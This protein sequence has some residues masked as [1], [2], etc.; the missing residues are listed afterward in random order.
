MLKYLGSVGTFIRLNDSENKTYKLLEIFSSS[1][2]SELLFSA[3]VNN[4]NGSVRINTASTSIYIN[5]NSAS[6][7]PSQQWAHLTF[8]FD[9]KLWTYDSNNFLIRFG[10]TASSNFNIQN[11]YIL[12][13]ST[14]ASDAG[15]LHYAFTGAGESI[16][17]VKDTASYSINVID[18]YESNFI[19]SLTKTV[20][21]PLKNQKRYL[22][23]I[24]AVNEESLSKYVSASTLVNDNLYI[25]SFNIIAGN[26]VLSLT[27]NQIYE[28][29]ASSKLIAI[30]S[31][32][33][34][35][36]KV[37]FGRQY[38]NS[39]YIKTNSGFINTPARPKITAFMNVFN[40]NNI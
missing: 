19:S 20:Y 12:E 31:S 21:Q 13:G 1:A 8:S 18:S 26:R 3:S 35:F 33:G 30:S 40:T 23:D 5:G 32:V 36:V 38:G 9:N 10:D 24:V 11:F 39:F 4:L 27:D 7:L 2:A 29:T 25:D 22:C 34:D 37:L 16:L 17:R 6:V 28:V 14:S 15:Y